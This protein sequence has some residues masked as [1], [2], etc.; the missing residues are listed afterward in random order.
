MNISEGSIYLSLK[1]TISASEEEDE[2][3]VLDYLK[4]KLKYENTAEA[5]A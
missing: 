1:E 3:N 4:G 5:I 2:K